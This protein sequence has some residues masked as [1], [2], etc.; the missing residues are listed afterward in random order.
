[1]LLIF[2]SVLVCG[3]LVLHCRQ[4][5]FGGVLHLLTVKALA[6]VAFTNLT[7]R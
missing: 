5:T 4:E 1:M 3:A 6:I 7:V 2:F